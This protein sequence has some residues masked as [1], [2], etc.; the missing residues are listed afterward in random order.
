ML[1][2]GEFKLFPHTVALTLFPLNGQSQLGKTAS[3]RAASAAPAPPCARALIESSGGRAP[4][5][6]ARSCEARVKR[7]KTLCRK[8]AVAVNQSFVMSDG[9]LPPL[10]SHIPESCPFVF[11]FAADIS[12]M[13]PQM[14][15][16]IN[17]FPLNNSGW[18]H[19]ISHRQSRDCIGWQ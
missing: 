4:E 18:L 1:I 19:R 12:D 16:S 6:R 17:S 5:T 10:C 13:R 2:W 14:S 7:K 15:Y 9:R 3:R 11:V 8:L